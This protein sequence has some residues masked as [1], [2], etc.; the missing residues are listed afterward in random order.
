GALDE[1]GLLLYVHRGRAGGRAARLVTRYAF[2]LVGVVV[3]LVELAFD[4]IPRAH[5]LGFFLQP[6]DLGRV[7]I[8]AHDRLYAV[9]RPGIELLDPDHGNLGRTA[10]VAGGDRVEGDL[11][12]CEHDAAHSSGIGLP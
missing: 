8:G 9:I 5:V 10:L 2:D 7:G 12:R 1:L 3:V 11:A 6:H 4:E